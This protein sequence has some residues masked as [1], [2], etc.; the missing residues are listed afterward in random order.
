M[1]WDSYAKPAVQLLLLVALT[2]PVASCRSSEPRLELRFDVRRD[3]LNLSLLRYC[4]FSPTSGRLSAEGP[5]SESA[6]PEAEISPFVTELFP[7]PMT[8]SV[9]RALGPGCFD[10]LLFDPERQEVAQFSFIRLR[11]PEA[12]MIPSVIELSADQW[13]PF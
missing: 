3:L 6:D 5:D 4:S 1:T 8:M 2:G 9:S 11:E 7:D 10:A 13:R 12:V